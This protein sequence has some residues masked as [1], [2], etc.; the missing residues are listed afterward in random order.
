ME[1]IDIVNENNELTGEICDREEVHQKGLWHREITVIIVNSKGQLLLQKR[2]MTKVAPNLWSLTAGHVTSGENERQAALRETEEE[3]GIKNLS[4]ED[5]KLLAVEKTMRSRGKHINHKFDNLFLLKTDLE[6]NEF[7]LQKTEVAEVR[8]FTIDE[9]KEICK[10]KDKYET[11]FTKI[12]FQEYFYKILE[13]LQNK[14]K[15]EK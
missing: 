14:K 9:M 5:F 10:N 15:E 8:Y 13:E 12:F 3:L 2:G 1:L 6:V 11:Q 7:I 4:Q